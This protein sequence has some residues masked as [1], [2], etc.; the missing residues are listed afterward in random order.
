[1]E[2]HKK[3][4]VIGYARV[5]TT[6]QKLEVQLDQLK[7][8]GV[9][10]VFQEKA[11]GADAERVELAKLLDFVREGDVVV[12]CKLDRLARSTKHLLEI[13]ETIEGK[14]ASL[15]ILNMSLDTSTPNGRLMITML[16]GIATFE[17][18]M[19]LERQR[20][21][22]AKAKEAGVYT[23]RKP[24]A[25]AKSTEVMALLGQ[26]KTKEAVAAELK[27]GVA[28]VYRIAKEHRAAM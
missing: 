6:D 20:D 18:E 1:M 10:R 28:S 22:I 14:G 13:V 17:R 21:G 5:S 25:K 15:K 26:G 3:N 2:K 27:I 11:S 9:D 16:A 8:A 4:Q 24:T 23:G 12:A 7:V 19:M